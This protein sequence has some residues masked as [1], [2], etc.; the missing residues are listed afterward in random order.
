MTVLAFTR[1]P[2]RLAESIAAA[3]AMGF[4]VVAAPS[5]E[6][7]P[8]DRAG[9]DAAAAAIRAGAYDLALF[10]SATAVE[11]SVRA[12]GRDGFIG[13][14]SGLAVVPIGPATRMYIEG[15]GVRTEEAP[16]E[17]TSSG[18][19]ELV[20]AR[21]PGC[22]PLMVRSDHGSDALEGGLEAAG[23]RAGELVAYKLIKAGSCPETERI[24]RKGL[25]GRIDVFAF[26]SPLSADAF[27]E[28]MGG[29]LEAVVGGRPVA[30]IGAPTRAELARLGLEAAIVPP[31]AT[32]AC[33][34]RTIKERMEGTI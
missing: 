34:L 9:F 33:L 8:G 10:S 32:F 14:M 22:R 2:R 31:E 1:P 29:D 13:L 4:D 20:A 23:I 26:T 17:H 24:R 7:V 15:M 27:A 11:E 30:A 3:E 25:A 12:W 19:A 6:V 16:R 18:L 28:A 5:L 21:H